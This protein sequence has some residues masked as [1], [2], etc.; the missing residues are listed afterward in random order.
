MSWRDLVGDRAFE[1]FE[2]GETVETAG[3][4]VEMCDILQFA[5]LTG[6]NYPLHVNED[7]AKN[8][9]FGGRIA[10]GPL[11]FAFAVGQVALT[12]WYG[13]AILALVEC[14]SMQATA[15]VRPGDT[16]R[17]RA[18]VAELADAKSPKNG[19]LHVDYVVL[20]QQEETVMTFHW[21][22]LAR[23]RI[24]LESK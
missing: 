8:T 9:L 2:L 6:D 15:P 1:D 14:Q 18:T 21:I 16:I 17:V 11:T 24:P 3:R 19:T 7:Y 12:G 4:T 5:G 20:N 22:M 13:N 10:H 23:R